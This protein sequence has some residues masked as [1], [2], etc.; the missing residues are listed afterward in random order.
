VGIC[1]LTRPAALF[2][3]GERERDADLRTDGA[4]SIWTVAGR[5]HSNHSISLALRPIFDCA[6]ELDSLSVIERKGRLYGRVTL[7]LEAREPRGSAPGDI[8]LN[9]TNA[10]VAVDADGREFF[11]SGKATTVRNARTMQTTKR[12]HRALAT[13]KAEGKDT[14]GVRRVRT[15]LSGRR[16]RRTQDVARVVA[17]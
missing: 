2:L 9:E 14:H 3:V 8:D 1:A 11:A 17:K 13:K 16:K 10:A 7:T 5:K 6:T 12:V 4:L 15:R